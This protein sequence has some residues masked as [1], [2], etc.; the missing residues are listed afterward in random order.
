M[1]E[2]TMN[3]YKKPLPTITDANRPYW[4]GLKQRRVLFQACRSCA[5][6]RVYAFRFCPHCASEE[7]EWVEVSGKGEIWAVGAFHQVYFEGFRDEVPYN[8]VAVQLDGGPKIYSN[9]VGSPKEAIAIGKRVE[10]VFEDVTPE[11]TLLKFRIVD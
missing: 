3:E 2:N 10:P 8:V 4:A 1:S 6:K 9:V 11:V 5:E 7:S